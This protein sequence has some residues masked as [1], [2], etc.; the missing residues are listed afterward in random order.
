MLRVRD[1][2]RTEWAVCWSELARHRYLLMLLEDRRGELRECH[3]LPAVFV[4]VGRIKPLHERIL[5]VGPFSVD[6]RVPCPIFI[7]TEPQMQHD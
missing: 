1:G 4:E 3:P 7:G 5:K 2:G 6:G